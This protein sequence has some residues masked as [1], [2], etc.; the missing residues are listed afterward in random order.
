MTTLVAVGPAGRSPWVPVMGALRASTV[1]FTGGLTAV[2][3]CTVTGP[4]TAPCG[5]GTLI[6]VGEAAVT[7]VGTPLKS[8]V[9]DAGLG[10]KPVPSRTI[11]APRPAAGGVSA[12]TAS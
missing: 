6:E 7:A 4:L 12:V 5:T 10:L 3:T 9:F 8:T 2:P 11:G 1:K